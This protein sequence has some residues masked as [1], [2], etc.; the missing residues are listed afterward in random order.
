MK[1]KIERRFPEFQCPY[2]GIDIEDKDNKLMHRVL[3]VNDKPMTKVTCG[4]CHRRFELWLNDMDGVL[5]P[6]R[7]EAAIKNTD[8]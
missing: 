2:C 8:G 7:I 4:N 5:V 1:L 3:F 6:Y